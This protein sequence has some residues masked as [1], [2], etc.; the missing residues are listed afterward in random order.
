MGLLQWLKDNSWWAA[1]GTVLVGVIA[2]IVAYKYRP[3]IT[4]I[5]FQ[6]D[7]STER[8]HKGVRVKGQV[9]ITAPTSKIIGD[10]F[11][12]L[13]KY[14]IRLKLTTSDQIQNS[15]LYN[16][17]FYGEYKLAFTGKGLLKLKIA[18]GNRKSKPFKRWIDVSIPT[19]IDSAKSP[20]NINIFG[21]REGD[22]P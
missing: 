13:A 12:R 22:L 5:E 11:L 6:P 4:Y 2:V 10:G 14:D 20:P 8:I 17:E 15:G 18:L 7:W 16:M 3:V 19:E 21:H 9:A 1:W